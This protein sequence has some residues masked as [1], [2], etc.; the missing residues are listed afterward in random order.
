MQVVPRRARYQQAP[1]EPQF[2]VSSP[3]QLPTNE[4]L[5]LI[6]TQLHLCVFTSQLP[7]KERRGSYLNPE[8]SHILGVQ[9]VL[10]EYLYVYILH[11]I[12][13]SNMYT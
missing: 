5:G 1:H 9:H 4:C 8:I 6:C 11:I 12:S 10:F 13:Y 7:T 2:N 3:V